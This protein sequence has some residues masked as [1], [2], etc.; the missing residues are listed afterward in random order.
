M[1]D[2]GDRESQARHVDHIYIC[3]QPNLQKPS[4]VQS[5]CA[6]GFG[7]EHVDCACEVDLVILVIADEV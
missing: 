4:I 3:L 1:R 5:Y 7:G 2:I 6:R